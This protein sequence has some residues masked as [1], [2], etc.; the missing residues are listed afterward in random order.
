MSSS[1]IV[2]QHIPCPVCPS[3]DAYCIYDDGHGYCYSCQHLYLPNNK[4]VMDDT[5]VTYEHLP[6]REI[7]KPTF[8]FYD[9]KTAV[10]KDGKPVR[11]GFRYSNGAYKIR[12]FDQKEFFSKPSPEG[13]SISGAGLFGRDRFEI[14]SH[15]HVIITEGEYDALALYNATKV[16]T[17][18][19]QSSSSAVRD[20]TV[21]RAFLNSFERVY[22]AFDSDVPGR[23]AT[24]AVSRLFDYD[25]VF[26]IRFTKYK[27]GNDYLLN[28]E[29]D[30]LVGLYH[31]AKR[32]SPENIISDLSAFGDILGERP[33]RGVPYPWKTLDEM[34][35]GIH[36]G[37]TILI[38]APEGIG[39]T[40]VMHAIE[41]QL[42]KETD[43]NVG[44]IYL[45]E[46][47]RRHL[48]ALA[49]LVL[50][51]PVHLPD[52]TCSPDQ[53]RAAVEGLVRK[54]GR[55]HIYDHYGSD[56]ADLL[57]DSIRYLVS[58]CGCRYVMLDHISM[59]VSMGAERDERKA[60]DR[61]MTKLEM[62]VKELNFALIVVS[63][64]NDDG[65]TRGSRYISKI[66]HLRIDLKRNVLANDPITRN[67]TFLTVSKNRFGRKT[68]PA[69]ALLFNL[70]THSYEEIEY[71]NDND[72][73]SDGALRSSVF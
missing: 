27:D 21:D 55:L 60:L 48:Q 72:A 6:H 16:P 7:D 38:T 32:Y 64:V 30:E 12:L 3:S 63:H 58:A 45:E 51:A 29:R 10:D 24:A 5:V 4:N 68:G 49:G 33:E 52:S 19:V 57:L 22:L 35:Y 61:I 69:G 67:T 34:T 23:D 56:D 14:G 40:E 70:D 28:G 8:R 9:V 18:S 54:D 43:A 66:A 20:C 65:L 50:K 13:A 31:S 2:E 26:D 47:K 59:V 53:V 73:N 17:V 25:K 39:K 71:A 1:K 46:D 62:M 37:Q 41:Y 36:R 42:L 44:A 11:V 15:K